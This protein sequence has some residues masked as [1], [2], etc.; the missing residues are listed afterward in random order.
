LLFW[1]FVRIEQNNEY[2]LASISSCITNEA[3]SAERRE[4]NDYHVVSLLAMTDEKL[5]K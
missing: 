1:I 4:R 5:G 3:I 2:V